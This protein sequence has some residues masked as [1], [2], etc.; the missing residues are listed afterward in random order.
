MIITEVIEVSFGMR[1]HQT[2]R[3]LRI[4]ISEHRSNIGNKDQRPCLAR[5]GIYGIHGLRFI[6]IEA[7][8]SMK[9]SGDDVV[10]LF[11]GMPVGYII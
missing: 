6:G 7:K 11:K 1:I 10:K 3:E 8:P 5:H 2:K 4:K 9:R